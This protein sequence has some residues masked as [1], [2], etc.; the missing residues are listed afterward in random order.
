MAAEVK[1]ES[2]DVLFIDI[3]GSKFSINEQK[4]AV[5]ELIQIGV[6]TIT[7]GCFKTEA[8]GLQK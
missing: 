2:A 4:T 5:D 3:V 8:R 6:Q 1:Q 7:R